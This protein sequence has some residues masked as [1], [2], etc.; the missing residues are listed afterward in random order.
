MDKFSV[1]QEEVAVKTAEVSAVKSCPDCGRPLPPRENS[2]ALVCT[3]C[4]SKP[5][6]TKQP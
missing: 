2:N 6:E 3:V 5:W 4:G 1:E